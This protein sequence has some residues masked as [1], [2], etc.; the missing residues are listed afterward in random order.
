MVASSHPGRCR[1]IRGC[2]R[3]DGHL[4]RRA[5]LDGTACI[6]NARRFGRTHCRFT[7]PYYLAMT[8]P[9]LVFGSGVTT[10]G[11]YAWIALA[12]LILLGDTERAWGTFSY[13]TLQAQGTSLKFSSLGKK[14]KSCAAGRISAS[15][16]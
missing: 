10:A 2:P 9:V 6:L 15:R 4:A 8:V 5:C 14:R 16:Q 13:S 11:P 12:V 3:A 7:G 1:A